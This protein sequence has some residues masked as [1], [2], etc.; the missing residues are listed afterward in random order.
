MIFSSGG[1]SCSGL[2]YLSGAGGSFKNIFCILLLFFSLAY[3]MQTEKLKEIYFRY[4]ATISH[5]LKSIS[6]SDEIAFDLTQ[7][8]FLA[9]DKYADTD[10]IQNLEAYLITIARNLFAKEARKNK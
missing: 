2:S 8:T 4:S 7:E 9:L 1:K 6:G 5:Y 10:K 3:Y